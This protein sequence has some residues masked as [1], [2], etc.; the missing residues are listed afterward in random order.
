MIGDGGGSAAGGGSNVSNHELDVSPKKALSVPTG[1]R[2]RFLDNMA[3]QS[4]IAI[5][6]LA[7]EATKKQAWKE[8][9][10]ITASL[11]GPN[12]NPTELILARVAALDWLVLRLWESQYA[13]N[14]ASNEGM[15]FA[16]S[17]HHQRRIDRTHRRLMRTIKTL[18]TVRRLALPALQINVA[19][20]QVNQLR[21]GDST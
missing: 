4:T 11:A 17:E 16:R 21:T 10:E 18:A 3:A 1:P 7:N 14:L 5:G 15:S 20:Q 6:N 2:E 19:H 8:F 12:P 13:Q 9:D